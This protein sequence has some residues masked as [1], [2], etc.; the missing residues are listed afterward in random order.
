[1][2]ALPLA[3]RTK[4]AGQVDRRAL[5]AHLIP[6]LLISIQGAKHPSPA[7]FSVVERGSEQEL[8]RKYRLRIQTSGTK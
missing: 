7:A 8:D 3:Y 2:V 1:M 5:E 4:D 6:G